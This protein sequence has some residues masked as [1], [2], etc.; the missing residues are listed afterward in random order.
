MGLK[1]TM[2]SISLWRFLSGMVPS[3]CNFGHFALESN[4]EIWFRKVSSMF[5]GVKEVYV[6]VMIFL[7]YLTYLLY[8]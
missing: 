1:D 8:L 7:S 6:F 3:S 5:A 2:I 4:S